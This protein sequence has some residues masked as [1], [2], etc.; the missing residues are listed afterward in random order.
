MKKVEDEDK[1]YVHLIVKNGVDGSEIGEAKIELD[2]LIDTNLRDL[3]KEYCVAL[4]RSHLVEAMTL[5]R[6][7]KEGDKN[8]DKITKEMGKFSSYSGVIRF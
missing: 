4:N 1:I 5:D 2:D 8:K 3:A 7:N 6:I